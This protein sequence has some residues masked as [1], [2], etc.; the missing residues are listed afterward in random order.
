MPLAGYLR[1]MGD[2]QDL[3]FFTKLPEQFT[4]RSRNSAANTYIHFVKDQ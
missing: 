1:L 2:T 4:N 3:A